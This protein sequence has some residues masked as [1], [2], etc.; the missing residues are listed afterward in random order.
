MDKGVADIMSG[1]PSQPSAS[2]MNET[3]VNRLESPPNTSSSDDSISTHV[4]TSGPNDEV[5]TKTDQQKEPTSP[6]K[7]TKPKRRGGKGNVR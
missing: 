2:G 6:P 3:V 4:G 7:L 5:S 1:H